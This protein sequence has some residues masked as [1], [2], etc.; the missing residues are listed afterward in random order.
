MDQALTDA[1]TMT[2]ERIDLLGFDACLMGM[3]EV[4]YELQDHTDIMVFSEETIPGGG[5][6]TRPSYRTS[7]RTWR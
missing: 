4:A 5:G 1:Y 7:R 2:G 6:R 3:M